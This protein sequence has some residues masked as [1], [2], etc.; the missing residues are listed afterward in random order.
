MANRSHADR[1]LYMRGSDAERRTSSTVS[2]RSRIAAK[3]F[4]WGPSC[5][6]GGTRLSFVATEDSSEHAAPI[7]SLVL[8]LHRIR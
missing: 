1:T 3:C 5:A 2:K 7:A 8:R 6:P 4:V